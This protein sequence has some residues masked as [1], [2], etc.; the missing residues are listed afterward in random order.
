MWTTTPSISIHCICIS[1]Q[2]KDEKNCYLWLFAYN[3]RLPESSGNWTTF[4]EWVYCYLIRN[5]LFLPWKCFSECFF[6]SWPSIWSPDSLNAKYVLSWHYCLLFSYLFPL[7]ASSPSFAAISHRG[8]QVC[9]WEHP[10]VSSR[11]WEQTGSPILCYLCTGQAGW[12]K[13]GGEGKLIAIS[14]E[15]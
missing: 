10:Q 15:V 11:Q 5:I 4:L 7:V 3:L 9:V 6:F 1:N 13:V 12:Q 14:K 8:C 2:E